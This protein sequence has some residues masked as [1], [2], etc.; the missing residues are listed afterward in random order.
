VKVP[1]GGKGGM[2]LLSTDVNATVGKGIRSWLAAKLRTSWQRRMRD[3]LVDQVI[4]EQLANAS[5]VVGWSIGAT[6]VGRYY[7]PEKKVL[8][9]ERSFSVEVLDAPYPLLKA[10]AE[11]LRQAFRQQEVILKSYDTVEAEH[12]RQESAR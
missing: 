3:T 8:Y 4:L 2:I 12:I 7:D 11:K 6:V 1:L 9:V 5:V 10:I